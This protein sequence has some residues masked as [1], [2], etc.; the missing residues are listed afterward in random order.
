TASTAR[1]ATSRIRARTSTGWLRRAAAARPTRRCEGTRGGGAPR[2]RR[3][4]SDAEFLARVELDRLAHLLHQ[5][6]AFR[7]DVLRHGDVEFDDEITR[8]RTG[9]A[10]TLQAQP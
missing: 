5:G 4:R 6:A 8:L 10:S 2:C 9:Q 1:P 7:V 3:D